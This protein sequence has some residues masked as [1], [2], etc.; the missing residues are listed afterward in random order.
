M[1]SNLIIMIAGII[2][3]TFFMCLLELTVLVSILFGFSAVGI[4]CTI[5]LL[6]HNIPKLIKSINTA[7]QACNGQGD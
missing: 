4:G 3:F 2:I 5:K 6:I 1:K 7:G